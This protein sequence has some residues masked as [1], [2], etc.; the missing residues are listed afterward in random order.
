VAIRG[1]PLVIAVGEAHAPKGSEAIES[2]AKR[3]TRELLPALQGRASDLLVELMMPPKGCKAT[4]ERAR[5]NQKVVTDQQAASNQGEYVEMGNA[6]KGLG[7]VP[8]LLRP[9][10][11]DLEAVSK[12]PGTSQGAEDAVTRSLAMIARLTTIQAK[13]LLAR[14]ARVGDAR[15]VALYGGALHNDPNPPPEK[16]DWSFGPALSAETHARYVAIDL[17]VPE[18]IDDTD[19]WR[20]MSFYPYF[21]RRAHADKTTLFH[22]RPD[23]YVLIFPAS[24]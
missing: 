3:F 18:Y 15:A 10:C 9:S 24:P 1:A 19:A 14:D 16:A 21:D 12:G 11:E 2:A 13:G 6:A 8:D 22:P 4:T 17:F 7:I 5:A 23:S 20:K